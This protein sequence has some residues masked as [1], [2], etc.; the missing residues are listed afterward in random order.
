MKNIF[1]KILT[2]FVICTFC[3]M[4]LASGSKDVDE[5]KTI[6]KNEEIEVENEQ[7][8]STK[9]ETSTPTIEEQVLVENSGIKITAKE[10]S[11]NWLGPELKIL[12]EN[13]SDKNVTVSLDAIAVNDYMVSAWL[14]EDVSAGKKSNATFDIYSSTLNDAGITNIGKIDLYFRITNSDTYSTIYE[15]DEIEIKT[16]LYDQMDSEVNDIGTEMVNQNGIRI[17]G[18]GVANDSIWGDGIV[19][20]IENNSN[21]SILVSADNL[22][23]NGYMVTS[24][25]YST[26]KPNKKAIESII[27]S[28]SDLEDNDIKSIEE[29]TLNLEVSNS[30]NYKKLFSTGEMS[31]N[32]E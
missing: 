13:D 20:Y 10:I 14:Y 29:F 25:L 12:I 1:K 19:L 3:L 24:F 17:I 30:T 21:N 16:S 2:I 27:L 6:T 5:S 7:Q 22:S 4:A 9:E 11:E 26:V 23:V 18:K 32:I 28:S 15:S 8:E 31:F